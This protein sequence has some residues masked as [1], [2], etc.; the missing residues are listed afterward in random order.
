MVA[1]DA[2]TLGVGKLYFAVRSIDALAASSRRLRGPL[3]Q[4]GG[5]DDQTPGDPWARRDGQVV[6]TAHTTFLRPAS[7]N[8]DRSPVATQVSATDLPVNLMHRELPTGV[9]LDD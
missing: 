4:V 2:A 7:T 9:N 8:P 1:E 3:R 5:D 6:H